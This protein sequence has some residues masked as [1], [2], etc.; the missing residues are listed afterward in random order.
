MH[1]KRERII[2]VLQFLALG[3]ALFW[4]SST[5]STDTWEETSKSHVTLYVGEPLLSKGGTVIVGSVPI[6]EEEW[7]LLD[8]LNLADAD[9]NNAKRRQVNPQDRLFGAYVSGPV[10]YVEMYYP[11]GGTFG[12]NLVPDPKIENSPRLATER[13]LV[14]SGGWMDRRTGE[15]HVWPDVSVIHILGSTADKGNSRLVRIMQANILNTGPDR[16]SYAG[17]LVYTPSLVQLEE[18]TF[19]DYK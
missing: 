8:G 4:S 5:G 7:R 17:V 2:F 14:G 13:I 16:K 19:G 3:V 11:E 15:R 18:G 12:F 6:P 9:D 1:F 10:S